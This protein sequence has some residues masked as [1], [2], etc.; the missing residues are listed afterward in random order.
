MIHKLKV[1]NT[2]YIYEDLILKP[3]NNHNRQQL[4]ESKVNGIK[5]TNRK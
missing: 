3:D 2:R 5:K 1:F 4:Y